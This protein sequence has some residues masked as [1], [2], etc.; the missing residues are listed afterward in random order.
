[1]AELKLQLENVSRQAEQLEMALNNARTDLEREK[2]NWELDLA[3]RVEQEK[4]KL[5]DGA[6]T[7]PVANSPARVD[8]PVAQLRKDGGSDLPNLQLRRQKGSNH[9]IEAPGSAFLSPSDRRPSLPIRTPD[10]ST[11]SRQDS[12]GPMAQLPSRD[13]VPETPSIRTTDQDDP[14][15]SPSSPQQTINDMISVTTTGAGPSVQLVERMSATVRR[16]NS[17]K[18][19]TRDELGRLAAQRDDAR[20]Q[21]VALMREV[22]QKRAADDKANKLEAEV[23]QLNE[24]YQTTLEMLGEK[25]E[26]VEELRADIAD[27]KNI[28]RDLLDKSMR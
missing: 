9:P 25:S 14:F 23:A 4:A 13:A 26:L 10:I 7:N 28:Y 6:G 17:E 24:R 27:M 15:E 20:E 19:A 21:I 11:V 22:E 2:R 8:S 5:Q 18:A 1:M 16:L 12:F 3:R